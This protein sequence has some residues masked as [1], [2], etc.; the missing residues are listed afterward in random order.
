[1]LGVKVGRKAEGF[2][3]FGEIA[4][5]VDGKDPDIPL[6]FRDCGN[7]IQG[8]SMVDE[9]IGIDFIGLRLFGLG[10][11]ITYRRSGAVLDAGASR[12][13]S[14]IDKFDEQCSAGNRFAFDGIIQK[15]YC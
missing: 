3:C 6:V 12:I 5:A 15:R 13:S 7:N 4:N 1:M 11:L 10:C 14:F 2:T 8:V 9:R